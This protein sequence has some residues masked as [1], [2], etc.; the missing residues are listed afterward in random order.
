MCWTG[1]GAAGDVEA[2]RAVP[3]PGP[4]PRGTAQRG[5]EEL[6]QWHTVLIGGSITNGI[7]YLLVVLILPLVLAVL[8]LPLVEYRVESP[9]VHH[10]EGQLNEVRRAAAAAAAAAGLW[11]GHHHVC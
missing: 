8:I 1:D 7:L 3:L 5:E 11:P 10:L 4:P 6:W 9:Q 2:D